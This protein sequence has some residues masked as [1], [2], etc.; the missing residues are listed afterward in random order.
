MR[1]F[2][3][4]I[5]TIFLTTNAFAQTKYTLDG[6]RTLVIGHAKAPAGHSDE[7]F[8]KVLNKMTT[9]L[10]PQK[11]SGAIEKAIYFKEINKGTVFVVNDTET[12]KSDETAK[13]VVAEFRAFAKREKIGQGKCEVIPLGLAWMTD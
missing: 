9:I 4:L 12:Q 8:I 13:K 11:L 2:P 1:V 6:N 7:D 10:A 3:V 5:L